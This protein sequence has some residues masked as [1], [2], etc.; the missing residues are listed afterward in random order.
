MSG[1]SEVDDR[2]RSELRAWLEENR[3]AASDLVLP[4]SP[5][6][7]END[8]QFEF[9]RDWQHKLYGAGYVGAEWPEAY[10]GRGMPA[11]TQR[12]IE[13]ELNRAG[14]PFLLNVVALSWAGPIILRYGTEAQKERFI[15]PLLSADHIWCQGFSEPEAGSDLASLRTTAVRDGDRYAIEGHKVWTTLARYADFMILLARTNPDAQ[16]HAGISYFLAPMKVP[17][18]EVRPLVKMT[19]EGGFNQVLFDDV[20]IPSDALL[21]NEGQGWEIATATLSFERGASEGSAGSGGGTG[22]SVSGLIEM[23]RARQRDGRPLLEDPGVR[24][25]IATFAIEETAIRCSARR[26]RI[27]GLVADRPM[28]IPLMM[29]LVG[30]EHT[31]QLADFGCELQGS[32][33]ALWTDDRDAVDGGEWQHSYLNSYAGTIAGGT[34]E[35][36]RNILGEKVLGLPKTR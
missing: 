20:H 31:Q 18:V 10:G 1:S 28:V 32:A 24:D 26:S 17:G 13:A 15:A 19:G 11:G 27:P 3:P 9:L 2:Y 22:L 5:L 34:S 7:V 21:G 30:S 29:K 8:A 4:Q 14:V 33:A 16:K 12:V 36:V 23:A 35:I 6:A 25:R